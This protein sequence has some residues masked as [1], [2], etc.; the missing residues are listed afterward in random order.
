MNNKDII[1][2]SPPVWNRHTTSYSVAVLAGIFKK[3]AIK[4]KIFDLDIELYNKISKDE[5]KLWEPENG[6]FW[7][8]RNNEVNN[9]LKKYNNFLDK[10]IRDLSSNNIKLFCFNVTEKSIF[11]AD[12]LAEKIKQ[13]LNNSFIVYGGQFCWGKRVKERIK[14][15]FVDAVCFTEAE[16]CLINFIYY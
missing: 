3:N 5:K 8:N 10:K 6:D 1:L 14:N 9:L 4:Y 16:N 2:I 15:K 11:S 12:I 13:K 7:N